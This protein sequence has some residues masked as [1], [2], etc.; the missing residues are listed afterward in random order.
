[1]PAKT[2][3]ASDKIDALAACTV[4]FRPYCGVVVIRTRN[5]S[6]YMLV[7]SLCLVESSD[8]VRTDAPFLSVSEWLLTQFDLYNGH[9]IIVHCVC[10]YLQTYFR[11]D[12]ICIDE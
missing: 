9:K 1:M 5:V 3:L 12:I 10:T 6:E 7:L 4:P 11:Q 2:P 8:N